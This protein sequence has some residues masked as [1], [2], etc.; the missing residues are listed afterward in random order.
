MPRGDS[1]KK[2]ESWDNLISDIP[3]QQEKEKKDFGRILRN[4]KMKIWE[5][6]SD[7]STLILYAKF[8]RKN[9]SASAA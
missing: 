7:A 4:I 2:S 3:T 6:N 8:L 9:G 1:E 5:D